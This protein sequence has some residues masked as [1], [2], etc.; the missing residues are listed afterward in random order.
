VDY[1]CGG[2]EAVG[3][4]LGPRSPLGFGKKG[5]CAQSAPWRVESHC[6]VER[7]V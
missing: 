1:V 3:G 2:A 7:G 6:D 5:S 4:S